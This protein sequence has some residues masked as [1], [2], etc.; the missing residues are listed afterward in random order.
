V[1]GLLI[2]AAVLIL[3]GLLIVFACGVVLAWPAAYA[4]GRYGRHRDTTHAGDPDATLTDLP[5]VGGD[6][7]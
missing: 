4:A 2:G 5:A 7:T 6:G 3:I 1:T